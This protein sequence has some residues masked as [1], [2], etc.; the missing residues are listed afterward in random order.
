MSNKNNISIRRYK[1]GDGEK[2]LS[3]FLSSVREIASVDYTE[4]QI[5]A[6]SLVDDREK[7]ISNIQHLKP[8][9]AEIHGDIAGYSDLQSNGY[10][11]HFFVSGSYVKMG[12]GSALMHT[13]HKEAQR[14]NIKILSA[15]VSKTAE[16]FFSKH[17]FH[18]EKRQN[19]VRRGIELPNALMVKQ[20]SN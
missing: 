3:V 5:K 17:G 12:V 9:V 10:I 8:F 20:I 4:S 7:W 13:I 14:L 6:W 18:V 2:I 1:P 19:P 16:A 11:D 15:D